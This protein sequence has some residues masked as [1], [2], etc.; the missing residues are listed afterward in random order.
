MPGGRATASRISSWSSSKE[1]LSTPTPSASAF[2][3]GSHCF[4]R[5]CDAVSY[6]HRHL[7]IHRDI[8]PSNILV[9]AS[10]Q[11]KLLDFGIAKL[12]DAPGDRTETIDRFLTPN[13]ASPEQLRG[14]GA[15]RPPPTSTRS[16]WCSTRSSPASRRARP[17]VTRRPTHS[18]HVPRDL[19][20]DAG[21]ILRKALRAEPSE[22][23]ASVEAFA[24]DVQA[25]LEWRP[26][27]ARSGDLWYRSRRFLRRYRAAAASM[28]AVVVALS[29]GLYAVNRERAVAERRFQQVR[30]LANKVLDLDR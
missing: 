17:A 5:V 2:A 4:C 30:Q 6:A 19:P 3:S 8:K 15:T 28:L 20:T 26:V 18:I 10:G 27:Q 16:V 12:L 13:Y 9:D 23:Y 29:A 21:Y 22:R 14:R 25:F 7:V 24:N 1:C 11:P